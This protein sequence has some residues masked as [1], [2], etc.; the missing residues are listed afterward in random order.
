MSWSVYDGGG[1]R[2]YLTEKERVSFLYSAAQ[3]DADV[4][5]FCWILA[6]TGC[7][8]SEALALSKRNIDFEVGHVIIECLKKRGKKVFR[9][10]PLPPELLNLLRKRLSVDVL[11]RRS[12]TEQ[13]KSWSECR[14]RVGIRLEASDAAEPRLSC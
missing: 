13:P 8:I 3:R 12:A 10:I 7:R 1:Q 14:E 11:S 6:A 2:K 5:S 9:T 4:Y